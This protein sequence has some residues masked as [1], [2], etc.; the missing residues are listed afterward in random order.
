MV[1]TLHY[2]VAG[3]PFV[4]AGVAL[5]GLRWPAVWAGV[6]ALLAALAGAV[7]WPQLSSS[8]LLRAFTEGVGTSG[9]VLYVL[10]GGLLLYNV[11][12]TGGA[13]GEVSR[14]L[15]GLEPE[16][17]ALALGVVVGVA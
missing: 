6:A 3:A 15:G 13:I 9:S 10:F 17:E 4:V 2:V 11:L 8:G 7:A 5:L 1:E 12:S 14:F 16:K